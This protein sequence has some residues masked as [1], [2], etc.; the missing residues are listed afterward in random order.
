MFGVSRVLF[1]WKKQTVYSVDWLS[2][3]RVVRTVNCFLCIFY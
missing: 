1:E 3:F 2:F